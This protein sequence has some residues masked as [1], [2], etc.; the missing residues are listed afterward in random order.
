MWN[1]ATPP[2]R[3]EIISW[4]T[5]D[6]LEYAYNLTIVTA[7]RKHLSNIILNEHRNKLTEGNA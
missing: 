5:V 3:W 1:S 2:Y 7:Q 4:V 6:E